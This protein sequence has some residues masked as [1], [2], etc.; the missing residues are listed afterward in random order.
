MGNCQSYCARLL[1]NQDQFIQTKI[2][3]TQWHTQKILCFSS[4]SLI[5]GVEVIFILHYLLGFNNPAN[6]SHQIDWINFYN[7]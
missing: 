4:L 5:G 1:R 7:R 2:E 3:I 6:F